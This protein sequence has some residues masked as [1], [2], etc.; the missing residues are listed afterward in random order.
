MALGQAAAAKADLEYAAA[1]EADHQEAL[2]ILQLCTGDLDGA[3]T[4]IIRRL[5]DPA[6]RA[7]A[8]LLLSDFD[9]HRPTY[10]VTP[11]DLRLPEIKAR[12]DVQAAIARAGL[13]QR[14]R[15]QAAQ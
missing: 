5:D 9:P 3:A 15:L 14:F 13:V 7:D 4:T 2:T 10:P 1:H 6:N 11:D 8:L 12:A